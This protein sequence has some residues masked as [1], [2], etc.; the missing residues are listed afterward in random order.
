MIACRFFDNLA[1][2]RGIQVPHRHWDASLPGWTG[3]E[4]EGLVPGR[5][6]RPDGFLED[7]ARVHR[8]T[9]YLFHG[10]RWHGYPEGHPDHAAVSYFTNSRGEEIE[11]SNED[12]FL[13]TMQDHHAYQT[14]GYRVVFVWEHEF[15]QTLR[16]RF[17]IP[18]GSI[19]H[20]LEPQPPGGGGAGAGGGG[21]EEVEEEEVEE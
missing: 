2:V 12:N 19:L 5:R 6:L 15:Q 8:G 11:W 18:L 1:S 17:P 4:V 10:N 21:E 20:Q 7:P 14:A 13:R 9:V 3:A 16:R